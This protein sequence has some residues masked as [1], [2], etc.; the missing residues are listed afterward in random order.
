MYLQNSFFATN[1]PNEAFYLFVAG[2]AIFL[3]F[4]Y[5][6]FRLYQ[7]K[8]QGI[9]TVGEIVGLKKIRAAI[10]P[11]VRYKTA[12]GNTFTLQSN[13]GR[14]RSLENPHTIGD[15]VEIIYHPKK[16]DQFIITNET[17]QSA[18]QYLPWLG[19]V[20]MGIGAAGMLGFW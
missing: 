1:N 4:S 13:I 11:T 16:E 8:K 10:Y 18:V 17:N 2:V 15:F 20:L 9:P 12:S 14:G 7:L 5:K 19:V 3:F 6:N